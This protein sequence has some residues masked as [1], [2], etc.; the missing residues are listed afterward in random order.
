[1][2]YFSHCAFFYASGTGRLS[3][4]EWK[5]IS[6]LL[7]MAGVRLVSSAEDQVQVNSRKY[8]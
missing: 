4:A 5:S 6:T 8:F 1:M 3:P 7:F 2:K